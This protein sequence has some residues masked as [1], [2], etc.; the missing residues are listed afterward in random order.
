MYLRVAVRCGVVYDRFA[1]I[2]IDAHYVH[3][4]TEL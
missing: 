3:L 1:T 4:F 2:I